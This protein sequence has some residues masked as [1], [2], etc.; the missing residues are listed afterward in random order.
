[1]DE[2]WHMMDDDIAGCRDGGDNGG[3]CN[4]EIEASVLI[5]INT[6]RRK[7]KGYTYAWRV[8]PGVESTARDEVYGFHSIIKTLNTCVLRMVMQRFFLGQ[9]MVRLQL[10][11]KQFAL[12]AQLERNPLMQVCAH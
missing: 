7:Q 4:E 12:L 10:P 8:S 9:G 5:S 11:R 6:K 1:M 2:H 3:H